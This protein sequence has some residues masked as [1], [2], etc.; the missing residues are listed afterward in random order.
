MK[1]IHVSFA[2]AIGL[3]F[4]SSSLGQRLVRELELPAKEGNQTRVQFTPDGKYALFGWQWKDIYCW[5][6]DTGDF[7]VAFEGHKTNV[8]KY[9]VS[10]DGKTVVSMDVDRIVKAWDFQ[11]G[12]TLVTL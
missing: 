11:T 9:D 10:S 8:G 2:I 1:A 4:V 3:F 5:N 6:M 12:E 7:R